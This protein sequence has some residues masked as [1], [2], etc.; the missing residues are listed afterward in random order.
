VERGLAVATARVRRTVRATGTPSATPAPLAAARGA[1]VRLVALAFVTVV[2]VVVRVGGMV[3]VSHRGI[4]IDGSEGVV[5]RFRLV[6]IPVRVQLLDA[7]PAPRTGEG[8]VE[9]PLA[10]VAVVHD[11]GRLSS[12]TVTFL[13]TAVKVVWETSH[14]DT[15]AGVNWH[16]P[17][18]GHLGKRRRNWRNR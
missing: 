9:V 13:G 16:T 7:C 17:G 2:T 4:M 1:T 8:A 5:V 11:A 10:R 15:I 14:N 12:R 18:S 6:G 3:V